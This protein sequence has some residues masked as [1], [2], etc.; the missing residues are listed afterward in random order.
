M[1]SLYGRFVRV[2]IC[3]AQFGHF[4][5]LMDEYF[6]LGEKTK[7]TENLLFKHIYALL[8]FGTF[9]FIRVSHIFAQFN[10]VILIKSEMALSAMNSI[11]FVHTD[12]SLVVNW[13]HLLVYWM[14]RFRAHWIKNQ[15]NEWGPKLKCIDNWVEI[16]HESL[17]WWH[18]Q[19]FTNPFRR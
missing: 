8:P 1:Y 13:I 5:S 10:V 16:L 6:I 15:S 12:Q 17:H 9:I 2:S 4:M 18:S 3:D 19:M 11:E 14:E 7:S